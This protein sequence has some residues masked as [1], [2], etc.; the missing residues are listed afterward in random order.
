MRRMA[1]ERLLE[2]ITVPLHYVPEEMKVKE[3]D[4]AW[5]KLADVDNRLQ[6][7]SRRIEPDI[8]S[9]IAE[10]DLE[11]LKRFVERIVQDDKLT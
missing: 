4:I 11:P 10:N 3:N 9:D 8:L 5:Q 6:H 2:I 7:A 1:I